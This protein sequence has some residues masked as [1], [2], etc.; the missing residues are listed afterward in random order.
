MYVASIRT[1]AVQW[2]V[3]EHRKMFGE[4][5]KGVSVFMHQMQ[6]KVETFKTVHAAVALEVDFGVRKDEATSGE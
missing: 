3:A 1:D 5:R 2:K 6:R 4:P